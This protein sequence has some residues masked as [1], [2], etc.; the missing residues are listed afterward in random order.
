MI[1]KLSKVVHA[2]TGCIL[3][4]LLVDEILRDVNLPTNLK[5][6]QLKVEMFPSRLKYINSVL[7]TF[8]KRPVFLTA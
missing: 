4:S 3:T 5:G 1:D 6:L 8:M 2:F 7:F